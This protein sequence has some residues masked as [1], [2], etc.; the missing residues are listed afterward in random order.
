M[1]RQTVMALLL[2][3]PVTA[4]HSRAADQPFREWLD[5]TG[6][7][8]VRAQL[9]A[10]KSNGQQVTLALESGKQVTLPLR[11]LSRG[12]RDY[13]AAQELAPAE[14]VA[15]SQLV[16]GIQWQDDLDEAGRVA[17]A[18]PS[19]TDDRPIMCFRAL[20]IFP[21]SCEVRATL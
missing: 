6:T 18:G 21:D 13:V 17:A 11:R 19:P 3:L 10:E 4:G 12:D 5:N 20:G 2:L 16:R 15:E 9:I 8:A 1:R 7:Y 14:A